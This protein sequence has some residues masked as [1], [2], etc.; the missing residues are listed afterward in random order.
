VAAESLPPALTV[1]AR[2]REGIP[3]ALRHATQPV[4]GL[5]FHPESVLTIHG[6]AIMRNFIQATGRWQ[7]G[8]SRTQTT[9]Q[10]ATEVRGST[11]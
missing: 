11:P 6:T 8:S 9:A 10:P 5:Q 3:M 7:A 1:T 2:T 4:E